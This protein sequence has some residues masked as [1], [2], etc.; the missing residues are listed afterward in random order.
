M[1]R[2]P[3]I[4]IFMPPNILKAKVGSAVGGI[5]M[6]AI[7][8][9]EAAMET[10]KVEFNDWLA[11]DVARLSEC[12]DRFAAAPSQALREDLFRAAHDLKGQADTFGY[13]MI[14][15]I[16]ASLTKLLDGLPLAADMPLGLV[17][18]HAAAIR[19][20][21]RDKIKTPSD[22]IAKV[23]TEELEARVKETLRG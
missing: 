1:A 21:F 22:Q 17:D 15:R 23:L 8:R 18:A 5:D 4:E 2:Q 16:A 10:L 6:A 19:V 9:A 13:P 11:D 14:A 20:V 7:K 12:R 3:P